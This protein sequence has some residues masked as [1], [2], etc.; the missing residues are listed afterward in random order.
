M[1]QKFSLLSL[2]AAACCLVNSCTL[3]GLEPED[4]SPSLR[5]TAPPAAVQPLAL[6][7]AGQNKV[8]YYV[9]DVTP[10]GQGIL[11]MT[12]FTDNANIVVVFEGTLWELADTVHYNSGWMQNAYYHSK[13]QILEDIQTLRS[14]GIKVLMNVDDAPS[15]ST[16]TPF[17]TYNGTAYNYQQFAAFIN[18]C[19]TTVGFDGISLDVERGATDNANYRNLIQELGDYFGPLSSDPSN[20]MYIGAFYSGGAPGPIFREVAL[21][22]YLNFVMDMGYFQNNTTRFNYWANTLGNAKVML[23]M[24]YDDNSQASAI[25]EAQRH[26]T[27]DKAGIMVFAAN[28]NKTYTDAIFAA[29]TTTPTTPPP[30]A[31]ITNYSGTIT[32]QYTDWPTGEDIGK[33]IDNSSSTK[34]L[35]QHAAA[36]V[37]FQSNTSNVVNKYTITSANDVPARDPRNWTLQGS[38][39]GTTWT[40]INTQ[41]NQSFASRFLTKTY[42]FS[43]STAYTYYRLNVSAVQSGSIMQ[44]AEWELFRN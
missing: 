39:N 9:F 1:K 42:T 31:D 18:T 30:G 4:V 36:W 41:T 25:T 40:T 13:R 34:Y 28:K 24:S 19:V 33:L 44:M 10:A 2:A 29:L 37:R 32:S 38:N 43:N 8:A 23:G 35:T 26:P 16:S 21:S 11:P 17:T 20:K 14:R 7:A 12:T 15:W 5:D 6:P 27:P 3:Q 22:Q